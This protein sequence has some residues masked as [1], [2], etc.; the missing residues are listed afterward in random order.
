MQIILQ[1]IGEDQ[2]DRY[3][4]LVFMNKAVEA[5][6]EAEIISP[7]EAGNVREWLFIRNQIVHLGESV[8]AKMTKTIVNE[9]IRIVQKLADLE[10]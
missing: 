6:I 5:A 10:I 3:S 9:V 7:H 2:L 1:I 4:K 8:T